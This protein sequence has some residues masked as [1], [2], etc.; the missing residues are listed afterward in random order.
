MALPFSVPKLW[1]HSDRRAQDPGPVMPL[2]AEEV[3]AT[4]I[5]APT[6]LDLGQ[7]GLGRTFP[8]PA[9]HSCYTQNEG[10][11]WL[12]SCGCE[13]GWDPGDDASFCFPVIA[14]EFLR[15][16]FPIQPQVVS[17]VLGRTV[18]VFP[19]LSYNYLFST[20]SA[21]NLIGT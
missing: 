8:P 15:A 13:E 11:Y 5:R 20:W 19:P 17:R 6:G 9:P 14:D 18:S 2:I 3:L 16:A 12:S 10:A 1:S 4:K 7:H 21:N